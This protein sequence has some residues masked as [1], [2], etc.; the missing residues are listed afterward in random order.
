MSGANLGIVWGPTLMDS[1]M[2][3]DAV[4]LGL[5]ARVVEIIIMN[6]DHI[7]ECE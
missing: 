4:E 5:A 1:G 3:P 7:F 6:V 2:V